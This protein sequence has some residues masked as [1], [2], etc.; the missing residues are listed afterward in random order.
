MAATTFADILKFNPYHDSKGR[1]ASADAAASFTY[2][3]GKSTAH[4]NAIQRAKDEDAAASGKGFKGTLY[5]GSPATDIEEFDMS[6]AGSNTSSGEKLLY[7]TD[8]KQMA[9][10]FS[11]ERLEGSTKYF[12]RRGK[13][14]RVYEVDVEMKNP[15]DFRNLSDKDIDNILKLD[16]EGVLSREDV[17]SLSGNHQ[18][19]KT[20][21]DLRAESLKKLGYDGLIANTGKAGHYSLEYAV[22]DSKQATIRKGIIMKAMTFEDILKFNP[23]HD[24]RGRFSTA[25]A[26]TLFTIRT[27][28]P[29]KQYLANEGIRREQ[30]RHEADLNGPRMK[31]V[32][33]IED[34]IRNQ[35][36]ESAACVDKDGNMIFFKNGIA[37]RV[38]F[39]KEEQ[40]LCKD[41]TLTHNHP[42]SSMFSPE[43]VDFWVDHELQEIRATNREGITYVLARG[44]DYTK[45]QG[46]SFSFLYKMSRMNAQMDATQELDD[47]GFRQKLDRG[48]MTQDQANAELRK[49]MAKH[50]SD[51][52]AANAS[53]FNVEFYVE[54]RKVSKSAGVEYTAKSSDGEDVVTLDKDEE[55][56][57]KAVFEEWL[58]KAEK[59]PQKKGDTIETPAVTQTTKS[60]ADGRAVLFIGLQISGADSLAIEGGEKPED[61]HVTLAYGHF[62]NSGHDEA[63]TSARV[64]KAIDDIRD[65]I[66]DSIHFDAQGRFEAS[67]SSDGK[68]VIYAQVAAGQLEK[69]HDGL[70][71]ALRKQ[72]IELQ[73]TFPEYKPHMTLA[74]IEHGAD[75]ELKDLNADGT[76]TK[77]MIGHGWE[78]TKENNYTIAK[79]VDDKKLVFGWAS[80]SVTADGEQLEDL[81]H[82]IINPEDLE[83][84]VYEYVLNFR[85]TGEEHRPHLRK[86]GKLV[87]S[88]VFTLEKQKAMGL[89]EGILPVG[90]WIGF[91]IEDDEAWEKVKNGTYRMFSIEGKA[92]R[93]PV[94]KAAPVE[95][96][97]TVA[98]TEPDRFDHIQEFDFP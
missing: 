44:K 61:F 68:D 22:V 63:D 5:H 45:F 48:E 20:N 36:F 93:V 85:D 96:E 95:I 51:F 87:E 14:G 7:F 4:D 84:A 91:K 53:D 31:T 24:S 75:F 37:D 56:W 83:E 2:A 73:G 82:D 26:A 59:D 57:Y 29:D 46:E 16:I 3:P 65:L 60:M 54:K 38:G 76:V 67:E 32:H 9:E 71:D 79:T 8:S 50:L 28:N 97:P 81:Q 90:W 86:K 74:Y 66:P 88:C 89:P 62:D 1:F 41:R 12:Q 6:R 15:L 94:E 49:V 43:D 55:A 58:N 70:L 77:A 98:K 10:D 27:K 39:S 11:Y 23:Y 25:D 19:L 34:K 92:Q 33:A 80:I 40:E 13:K 42:S 72:G 78:S 18:L 47:R 52:W 17:K 64:Q 69:A 35:D 21:L 30:A